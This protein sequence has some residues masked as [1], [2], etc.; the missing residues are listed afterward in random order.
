MKTK[1]IIIIFIIICFQANSQED[2]AFGFRSFSV[3][4]GIY[5]GNSNS[6]PAV[7]ADIVLGANNNLIKFAGFWG[8]EMFDFGPDGTDSN[9]SYSLLYGRN[10]FTRD[11]W[12][13]DAFAGAGYFIYN[14]DRGDDELKMRST[15]IGF[16]I[17][18]RIGYQTSGSISLGLQIMANLN[19]A[20]TVGVVG[21]YLQWKL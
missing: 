17:E 7:S 4:P 9:E 1:F 10:L 19:S 6:G 8:V 5:A 2:Q 12:Y 11:S 13:I 15:A 20:N 3:A 21:L 18:S 14:A 16:P